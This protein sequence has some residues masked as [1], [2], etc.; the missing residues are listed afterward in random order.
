[1]TFVTRRR[2]RRCRRTRRRESAAI[3]FARLG[4]I[5]TYVLCVWKIYEAPGLRKKSTNANFLLSRALY[6]YY[7]RA[8]ADFNGCLRIIFLEKS[9]HLWDGIIALSRRIINVSRGATCTALWAAT[10]R[11]YLNERTLESN[12]KHCAYINSNS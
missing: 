3:L 1:M 5:K 4:D 11:R 8:G 2:C 9:I 12:H 10:M 7:C 6:R